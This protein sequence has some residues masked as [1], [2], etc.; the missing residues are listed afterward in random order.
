M[1]E[2]SSFYF[3]ASGR[4]QFLRPSDLNLIFFKVTCKKYM[5]IIRVKMVDL[6]FR[7]SLDTGTDCMEL[8]KGPNHVINFFNNNLKNKKS[9]LITLS[10]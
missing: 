3:V 6:I 7:L 5:S 2:K 9:Y 4:R 8:K 1:T 10:G